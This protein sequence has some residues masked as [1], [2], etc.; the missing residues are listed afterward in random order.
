MWCNFNLFLHLNFIVFSYFS[1]KTCTLTATNQH[2]M[3]SQQPFHWS[4]Y[5]FWLPSSYFPK[6][7]M[8]LWL[9]NFIFFLVSAMCMSS[10]IWT[11]IEHTKHLPSCRSFFLC[12]VGFFG[13][14]QPFLVWLLLQVY[15]NTFYWHNL[16]KGCNNQLL[17][18]RSRVLRKNAVTYRQLIL[19]G[20]SGGAWEWSDFC[21]SKPHRMDF[22]DL[23]DVSRACRISGS[24]TFLPFCGQVCL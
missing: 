17:S 7:R 18:S 8:L 9:L 14:K 24:H 19:M 11:A 21:V 10:C 23:V 15:W 2:L 5:N 20:I 22:V 13:L 1:R 4:H 12:V 16:I 3:Q 6:W